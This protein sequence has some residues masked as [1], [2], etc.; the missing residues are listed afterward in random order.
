VNP[1]DAA[2]AQVYGWDDA[3]GWPHTL[4]DDER[5][6]RLLAL[7]LERVADTKTSEVSENL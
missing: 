5:L 4:T 1:L 6:E 2:V 3:Y 7:K